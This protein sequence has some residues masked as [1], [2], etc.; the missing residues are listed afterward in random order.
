MNDI[1]SVAVILAALFVVGLNVRFWLRYRWLRVGL[2]RGSPHIL[3]NFGLTIN[4][5][6]WRKEE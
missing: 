3:D 4:L 2:G 6:E 5:D 1:V